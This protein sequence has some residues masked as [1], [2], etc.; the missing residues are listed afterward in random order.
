M[1][2][3]GPRGPGQPWGGFSPI[4]QKFGFVT[5]LSLAR[6]CSGPRFAS[7]SLKLFCCPHLSAGPPGSS[8]CWAV[9]G[10]PS[11]SAAPP[12]RP[13]GCLTPVRG[14]HPHLLLQKVQAAQDRVRGKLCLFLSSPPAGTH[15]DRP[16]ASPT[17][18][19]RRALFI[20]RT[21]HFVHG[22]PRLHSPGDFSP[23]H[24]LHACASP[25]KGGVGTHWTDAPWSAEPFRWG[26]RARLLISCHKEC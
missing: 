18:L 8:R 19:V 11:G 2:G 14:Q 24:G 5:G 9:P 3:H 16:E 20:S 21:R 10:L 12:R 13:P 17:P 7:T 23:Y 25:S 1:N 22:V 26:F 15:G 4:S 6:S